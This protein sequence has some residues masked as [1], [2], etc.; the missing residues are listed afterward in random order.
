MEGSPFTIALR[1]KI[2]SILCVAY[3]VLTCVKYL[4]YQ[5]SH[6]ERRRRQSMFPT[7]H[8]TPH[9]LTRT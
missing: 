9:P 6:G 4:S 5:T 7:A 1:T 3:Y 2:T 8:V